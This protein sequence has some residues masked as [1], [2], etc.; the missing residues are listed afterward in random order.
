M[1]IKIKNPKVI[2]IGNKTIIGIEG[3]E[4]QMK[5]LIEKSLLNKSII[6]ESIE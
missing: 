1:I 4:N 5:R 2:T 6:A 3:T